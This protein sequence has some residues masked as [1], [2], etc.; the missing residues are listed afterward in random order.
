MSRPSHQVE[1]LGL[2][3]AFHQTRNGA[4][5]KGYVGVKRIKALTASDDEF[6]NKSGARRFA[7]KLSRQPRSP[8]GDP[9]SE[10]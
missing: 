10:G 3:K 5:I 7:T 1:R 4:A 2:P 9:F 6:K 8:A